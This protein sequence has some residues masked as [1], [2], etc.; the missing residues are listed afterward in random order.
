M[1]LVQQIL[2]ILLTATA[3]WVFIR[4]VKFIS[5][6]IKLGRDEE[7]EPDPKRWQNVL[8]MAFGQKRMFDKPLVALLHFAVY[9]GFIII[10]IEIYTCMNSIPQFFR[11]FNDNFSKRNF[12][13]W[14]HYCCCSC[15]YS[16]SILGDSS[17]R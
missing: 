1:Q 16:K 6:N 17:Q 11:R 10:N 12:I 13:D 7:L 4:K 5:R 3:I 15:F 14:R 8:L 2:F 9:A